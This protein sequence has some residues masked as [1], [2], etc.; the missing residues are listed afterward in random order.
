[1]STGL[2]GMIV[3]LVLI[4]II[5]GSIVYGVFRVKRAIRSFSRAAFGTDSLKEGFDK[6]GEEYASTPKSVS[7]M[8]GLYLPKIKREFPE[9]QYDEMKVRAENVLTSY[10]MAI[11][12]GNAGLLKEGSREL[13]DKLEM[14]ITM[15][16]GRGEK[17]RFSNIKLHRTEI[18]DYK[19]RNGR[20]TVTFQTS[21]Q[22]KYSLMQE[23]GRV[24]GGN[25]NMLMQSRYNVDLVYIQDRNL[26]EDERDLSLGI[27]CPNCGAPISGLGSK[28]CE[29]CGTPVVEINIYAWT[30]HNVS[31]VQ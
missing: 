5:M 25:P 28:F 1:M 15:L 8:T 20:C 31:E 22:Y 29:Y 19:K 4:L 7:A 3:V 23:G 13:K 18:A 9:F 2:T 26:V 27:N 24:V 10:L 17:E 21:L 12:A 14:H 6:V 30:F 16:K 11:S